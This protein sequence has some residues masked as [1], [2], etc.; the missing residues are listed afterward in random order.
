MFWP[1]LELTKGQLLAYYRRI[2]PWMLPW[3]ADR[4]LVLTR[5]PDGIHGKHFFQH[6]APDFAPAWIRRQPIEDTND[7]TVKQYFVI[8]DEEALVYLA[9]LG[10]ISIH[11]WSSRCAS[12]DRP[13]WCVLDLDP[14][15]APFADVVTLARG[16]GALCDE[17][18]LPHYVK[19]TGKSGL[20]VLVPLGGQLDHGASRQLAELLARVAVSRFAEI[21]TLTRSVAKRHGRVYIDFM[22][23]GAGKTIAATFSAREVPAASVSMPLE[24]REL[25]GRLA[26]GRFTILN[27]PGRMKRKGR[28]PAIALLEDRPDLGAA[29]EALARLLAS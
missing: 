16:I 15:D 4:P 2:A 9:N 27:A 18:G 8:E 7:G 29:M 19:T 26:P 22:Q 21:A 28:D 5:Y 1:E 12:L 17:L 23:N 13:D 6:R 14:K 20:H 11:M 3:L 10:T 24:W 25:N